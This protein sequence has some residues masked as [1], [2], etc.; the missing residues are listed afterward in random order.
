ME[1]LTFP[2]HHMAE[3]LSQ[4]KT[5]TPL[6]RDHVLNLIHQYDADLDG[7]GTAPEVFLDFLDLYLDPNNTHNFLFGYFQHKTLTS[8]IGIHLWRALPYATLSYMFVQKRSKIFQVDDNGLVYCLHHC[9]SFGENQNIKAYYSLQ[10]YRGIRHKKRAWR[11]YDTP[12]TAKYYSILEMIIEAQQKPPF[13]IVFQLMDQ[14]I[15]PHRMGLWCTRLKPQHE[16]LV[17]WGH[18]DDHLTPT[19]V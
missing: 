2:S 15:W 16:T 12:L 1:S 18:G 9:L 10:R 7:N 19:K 11:Q 6:D 5:L 14:K 8:M 13:S 3:K 17:N 4:V